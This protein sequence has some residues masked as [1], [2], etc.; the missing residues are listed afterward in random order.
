MRRTQRVSRRQRESV[1]E[2]R[3]SFFIPRTGS[4][5]R[6]LLRGIASFQAIFLLCFFQVLPERG[7]LVELEHFFRDFEV[8][9][10]LISDRIFLFG[11]EKFS[12]EE[13]SV[14]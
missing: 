5:P 11:G 9:D 4:I 10:C 6:S 8:D 14:A 13:C 2:R 1:R 7:V 3:V 12:V